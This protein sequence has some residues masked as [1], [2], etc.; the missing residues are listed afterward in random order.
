MNDTTQKTGQFKT[1][2]KFIEF[3]GGK[4]YINFIDNEAIIDGKQ[5]S[6]LDMDGLKFK[7][8]IHED[9]V[10]FDE[11]DTCQ[12]TKE[13]RGRLLEIIEDKTSTRYRDRNV[14]RE[15]TFES[16][17]K[18]KDKIVPLHLAIEVS[19]PIDRLADIL[20]QSTVVSN[21]AL[22]ALDDLLKQLDGD[23]DDID[24]DF[25]KFEK[26]FEEISEVVKDTKMTVNDEIEKSFKK[27]KD[28]KLDDLKNDK[29]KKI[30]DLAKLE[31]QFNSLNE[32]INSIKDEIKLLAD[33]I[34]DI[35]PVS[36]P[37]G[38]FFNVSERQ[39]EKVIFEPEIEKVI[40]EKVSKIKSINVDNFM[41]L[42]IE[43]E[44]HIRISDKANTLEFD[45]NTLTDEIK[46]TL[47]ELELTL[48]D[49]KLIYRGELT[50]SQIVNKMIKLGFTQD[51]GFD[52]L[53]GSNSYK[54]NT[55]TKEDIKNTQTIF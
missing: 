14:I 50:W 18:V 49:S 9:G 3:V 55:D 22:S 47:S 4:G 53:C 11:V 51:P 31:Y 12:T 44:F 13:Q 45:Y 10:D 33:R 5:L 15:L 43:G 6:G 46:S 39:N 30:E 32:N 34:D 19:K 26:S 48:D 23:D 2:I 41:K 8:T 7:L 21:G 27:M 36:E 40:K 16:V 24:F 20:Q 52:E 28:Q 42:F 17:K 54:S 35:Q 25:D 38:Y 37:L 1:K 29:S